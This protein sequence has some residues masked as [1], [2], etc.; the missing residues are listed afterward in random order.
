MKQKVWRVDLKTKKEG[1]VE[2]DR[3]NDPIDTTEVA[4]DFGKL[5]EV[6]K[7]GGLIKDFTEIE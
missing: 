4:I 5:K 1:I 6:L 2:E 7:A 3:P